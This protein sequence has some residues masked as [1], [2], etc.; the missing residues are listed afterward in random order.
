MSRTRTNRR[1]SRERALPQTERKSESER[2]VAPAGTIA[3]RLAAGDEGV[4]LHQ[5]LEVRPPDLGP[6]GFGG[7]RYLL[8]EV[9]E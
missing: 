3:V 9:F 1:R 7:R 4:V 8:K 2:S 5:R 6:Q